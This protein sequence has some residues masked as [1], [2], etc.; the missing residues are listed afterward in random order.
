MVHIYGIFDDHDDSCIYIGVTCRD[1]VSKRW[2]E[3]A[4]DLERER[5]CNKTLQRIYNEI[6][7][8]GCEVRYELLSSIDTDNTLLKFFYEGLYVS[9]YRPKANKVVIDQGKNRVVLQR[10]EPDIAE[11]II[12]CIQE[13]V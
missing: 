4:N 8:S 10:C 12:E 5:H 9:L 7:K 1:P 2:M 11:K 3:H 13:I 6:R